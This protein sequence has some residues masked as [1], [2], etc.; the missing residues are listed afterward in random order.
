[1]YI[2]LAFLLL[3]YVREELRYLWGLSRASPVLHSNCQVL[4]SSHPELCLL[5]IF[6][7]ANRKNEFNFEIL[8]MFLQAVTRNIICNWQEST[9]TFQCMVS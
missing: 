7:T 6:E 5:L 1:M 3:F 4:P 2:F 8:M 9:E